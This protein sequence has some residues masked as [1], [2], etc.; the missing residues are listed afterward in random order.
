[1]KQKWKEPILSQIGIEDT[2]DDVCTYDPGHENGDK[3]H[4]HR[5]NQ[6][7]CANLP[8]FDLESA[9]THM[10]ANPGHSVGI[11]LLS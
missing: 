6:I 11:F 10:L 8:P 7:Q 4:V 2:N 1:M 3:P 5:C 9:R